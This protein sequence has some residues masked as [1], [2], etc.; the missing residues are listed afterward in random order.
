M[1]SAT[2]RDTGPIYLCLVD[3]HLHVLLLAQMYVTPARQTGRAGRARRIVV[4]Q[5]GR[6]HYVMR[7]GRVHYTHVG[8]VHY[9]HV[10]TRV[11]ITEGPCLSN[12]STNA[13]ITE[14]CVNI[15]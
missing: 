2:L 3:H 8:R 14:Q 7:R 11:P 9:T 1:W 15:H 5:Q 6:V 10:V 4:M 13:H 12:G